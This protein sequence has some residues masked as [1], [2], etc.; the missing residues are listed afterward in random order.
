MKILFTLSLPNST[1]MLVLITESRAGVYRIIFQNTQI[2]LLV[3]DSTSTILRVELEKV[4][5]I[6]IIG[7]VIVVLFEKGVRGK[8]NDRL[9]TFI[10]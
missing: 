1:K 3:L 2:Y 10:I 5:T 7:T 4:H 8:R 6:P 9:K